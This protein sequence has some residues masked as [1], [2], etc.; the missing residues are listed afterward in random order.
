MTEQMAIEV[1]KDDSCYECPCGVYS[2]MIC[3]YSGCRVATATRIAIQALEE[4]QQYKL[5]GSVEEF[6]TLKENS[7]FNFDSPIVNVDMKSYNKAI[8][9][10]AEQI[11]ENCSMS[12]MNRKMIKQIA[13]SM[14]EE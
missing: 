5:V 3:K 4:V 13:E 9:E 2:P 14:K 1:L 8:E 10:F 11:M 12:D 7:F 6:K